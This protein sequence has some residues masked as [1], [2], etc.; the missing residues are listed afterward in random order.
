[1]VWSASVPSG[2]QLRELKKAELVRAASRYFSRHG[3]H[4]TSLAD[5]ARDMGL[6]KSAIYHYFPD[7][8]ALLFECSKWAHETI[9][10]LDEG[11]DPN[12]AR[13]LALLCTGYARHVSE[14]ELSFIMFSDLEN[15]S[16]RERKQIIVLRDRFEQR[17]RTLLA[18][19]AGNPENNALDPKIVGLMLLGSL[20]WISKWLHKDGILSAEE[21]A[22]KF[23]R[24]LLSGIARQG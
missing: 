3:F 15:I 10:E 13:R 17:V 16:A 12:P 18:Q 2:D 14:N 19:I 11:D 22:D 8:Q 23:V 9:V 5:V 21:I 1:M 20:N 24:I 4:G 7:K 6:T